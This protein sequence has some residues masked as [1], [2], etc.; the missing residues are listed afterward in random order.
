V[1]RY[2]FLLGCF[3]I[4]PSISLDAQRGQ[5]LQPL[6]DRGA[7][8]SP[9]T[10]AFPPGPAPQN[11]RVLPGSPLLHA[12]AWDPLPNVAGYRVFKSIKGQWYALT[13]QITLAQTWTDTA[14]VQPGTAYRISAVYSDGRLGDTDFIYANPPQPQQPTGFT[15]QQVGPGSVNL[16]WQPVAYA[17]FY[18]IFG[19][20]QPT[21]GTVVNGTQTGF[22]KLADGNYTWM[23]SADYG[24]SYGPGPSASITLKSSGRY[25]VVANGFRVV[26]STDDD[27]IYPERLIAGRDGRQDEIYAGFAM[28]HVTR[29]QGQILDQDLRQTKV[30]GEMGK[31]PTR[32]KAG[33]ATFDGG[34]QTADVFPPVL[35]PSVTVGVPDDQSFPFLVWD[36][37]L[38]DGQDAVVIYPTMWESDG[39]DGIYTT[40]FLAE[41][42]E[43]PK[44]WSEATV[45]QAL[46]SKSISLTT[47][48]SWTYF[49]ATP[50]VLNDHPIG[51]VYDSVAPNLKT[52][53]GK[54]LPR[55]AIILT[56]EM[57]ES[58]LA[59]GNGIVTIQLIDQG[60]HGN[61]ANAHYTLYVQVQRVP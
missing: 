54:R 6:P 33:T 35:D 40:W 60:M 30:H 31:D 37:T 24:G 5:P 45:Q 13:Q 58:A 46:Q 49:I 1:R 32:V 61:A 56:R 51:S 20:G 4:L 44:V 16:T 57:I 38:T 18:R 39:K 29:P 22:T 47:P 23:V 21:D 34:L 12:L 3:A 59:S 42:A 25:R 48:P 43:L 15:V 36:G 41:R 8:T 27:H 28:F 50:M 17:A 11:V 9:K 26:I 2:F 52:Q 53:A 14:V 7:P 55:R 10:S 19:T